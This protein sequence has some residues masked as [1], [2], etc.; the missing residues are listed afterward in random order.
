LLQAAFATKHFLPWVKILFLAAR[1]MARIRLKLRMFGAAKPGRDPCQPAR[2]LVSDSE[3]G[4][5]QLPCSEKSFSTVEQA[6]L[7]C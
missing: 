3:S 6:S 2:C 4:L 5:S 1:F 7:R